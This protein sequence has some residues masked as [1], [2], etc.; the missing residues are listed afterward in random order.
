MRFLAYS[1]SVLCHPLFMTVYVSLILLYPFGFLA[2]HNVELQWIMLGTITILSIVIPSVFIV[3][4]KSLRIISSLELPTV[5]DRIYPFLFTILI[6]LISWLILKENSVF[7]GVLAQVF[8]F[9]LTAIFLLFCLSFWLKASAHVLAMAALMGMLLRLVFHYNEVNHLLFLLLSI[10]LTGAV[11][12]SRLLLKAHTM[13]EV[14]IGASC[15][16]LLG[17]IAPRFLGLF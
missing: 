11:A 3:G 7:K 5:K 1:F 4:L 14:I 9:G 10:L 2:I 15:G 12:S 13:L 16:L 8:L 6:Y 17:L